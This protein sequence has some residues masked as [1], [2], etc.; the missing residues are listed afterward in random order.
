M[1]DL[2]QRA[3]FGNDALPMNASPDERLPPVHRINLEVRFG[4]APRLQERTRVPAIPSIPSVRPTVTSRPSRRSET[5]LVA[6]H[7]YKT[8]ARVREEQT[9]PRLVIDPTL[10]ANLPLAA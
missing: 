5:W 3:S 10:A 4:G 2:D 7:G 8:P 6:R 9:M 1:I